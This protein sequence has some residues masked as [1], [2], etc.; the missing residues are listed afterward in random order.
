MFTLSSDTIQYIKQK[1][2]HITISM[3]FVPAVSG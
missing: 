3:H 1:G 2:S